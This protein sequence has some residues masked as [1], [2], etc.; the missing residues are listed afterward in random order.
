M[1]TQIMK[2][3]A[4]TMLLATAQMA[5]SQSGMPAQGLVQANTSSSAAS[6]RDRSAAQDTPVRSG[7]VPDKVYG[8]GSARRGNARLRPAVLVDANGELVGRFVENA[9]LLEYQ[10]DAMAVPLSWDARDPNTQSGYFTW[11]SVAIVFLTADCSGK[12]Y[13]YPNYLTYGTRYVA[14]GVYDPNA[15]SWSAYVFD[16][17]NM[18][19][20]TIG[21]RLQY[22]QWAK[23][24]TC[25]TS[26]GTMLYMPAVDTIA[27]DP[28]AKMPMKV[29]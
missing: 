24:M 14:Q 26:S 27:L 21:S 9:A 28:I 22:D 3:M 25:Y 23:T 1:A 11:G 15:K 12:A 8:N 6:D 2:G 29:E 7:V 13:G 17:N 16:H 19:V 4:A 5:W 10:G 18:E 20:V